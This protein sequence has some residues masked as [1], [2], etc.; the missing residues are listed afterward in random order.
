MFPGSQWPKRSMLQEYFIS[1]LA[2]IQQFRA[3][4]SCFSTI[5]SYKDQKALGDQSAWWLATGSKKESYDIL[6]I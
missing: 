6:P 3:A 5:Y 2:A 4:H 1:H